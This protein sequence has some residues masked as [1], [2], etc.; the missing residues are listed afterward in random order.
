MKKKKQQQSEACTVRFL[1][2]VTQI[3]FENTAG[4]QHSVLALIHN[5]TK[6]RFRAQ[7]KNSVYTFII[8]TQNKRMFSP[9]C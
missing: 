2:Y 6:S 1:L 7:L 8:G 4:F 5:L 3:E 9:S